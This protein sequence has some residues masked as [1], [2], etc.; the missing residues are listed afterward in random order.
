MALSKT[1]KNL[2]INHLITWTRQKLSGL[3]IQYEIENKWN[4]SND[5]H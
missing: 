3:Y 2:Q 5:L 4:I 1:L